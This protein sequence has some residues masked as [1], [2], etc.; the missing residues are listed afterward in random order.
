MAYLLVIVCTAPIF[1]AD[2]SSQPNGFDANL[3]SGMKS[4]G[5]FKLLRGGLSNYTNKIIF[6][7][8]P[9]LGNFK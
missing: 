7:P 8:N 4:P 6:S 2:F 1:R 5:Y 3:M 9:D